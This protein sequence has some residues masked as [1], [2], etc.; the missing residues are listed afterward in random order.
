MWSVVLVNQSGAIV[1]VL[2]NGEAE[3]RGAVAFAAGYGQPPVG[4]VV[5][6]PMS[7]VDAGSVD[8]G[9]PTG[10]LGGECSNE[11]QW[12][13]VL[14]G[15]EPETVY[16][17][18]NRSRS[19]SSRQFNVFAS[20]GWARE[21]V[22][23]EP[24]DIEQ[25]AMLL[26]LLDQPSIVLERINKNGR[27]IG[28]TNKS[29]ESNS[30]TRMRTRE[31][32]RRVLITID[33]LSFNRYGLPFRELWTRVTEATGVRV[34]PRTIQRDLQLLES[35]TLIELSRSGWR[36]APRSASVQKAA[37]KAAAIGGSMA[38]EGN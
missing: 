1:D 19:K 29:T 24:Y 5:V 33:Q 4:A 38:S 25:V 14:A 36:L 30:A 35:L 11:D 13:T 9:L 37:Q 12:A 21:Q 10:T 2:S 32:L 22:N 34:H 27:K 16:E 28:T 15:F 23:S 7:L 18:D 20:D 31:A 17:V 6:M 26:S 8:D 3:L